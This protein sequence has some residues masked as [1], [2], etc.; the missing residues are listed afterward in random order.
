[1]LSSEIDVGIEELTTLAEAAVLSV[2]AVDIIFPNVLKIII[3]IMLK[4][5]VF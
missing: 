4:I 5:F 1:M 2:L 3:I